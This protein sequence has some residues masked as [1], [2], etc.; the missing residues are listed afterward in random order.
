MK[1]CSVTGSNYKNEEH[2]SLIAS[3]FHCDYTEDGKTNLF[4]RWHKLLWDVGSNSLVFKL[5]L[6]VV[7]L[8]QRLEGS[9]NFTV[10]PGATRLLLV[11]EVE[12]AENINMSHHPQFEP[13]DTLSKSNSDGCHTV[14]GAILLVSAI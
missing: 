3:K 11:G 7:L 2:S 1:P 4:N 13:C 10:L 5:Q 6:G 14:L 9:D 8:L 12:S